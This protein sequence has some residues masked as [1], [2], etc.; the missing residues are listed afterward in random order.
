MPQRQRVQ[1]APGPAPPCPARAAASSQSR[2]APIASRIAGSRRP[3][4]EPAGL[5]VR[6]SRAAASPLA[7]PARKLAVSRV[8]ALARRPLA[9]S[10]RRTPRRAWRRPGPAPSGQSHVRRWPAA[11]CTRGSALLARTSSRAGRQR[12]RPQRQGVVVHGRAVLAATASASPRSSG[13][14]GGR[15]GRRSRCRRA[16]RG[17]RRRAGDCW[18]WR[19][20]RAPGRPGAACPRRESAPATGAAGPSPAGS[21]V[22]RRCGSGMRPAAWIADVPVDVGE[23]DA[24]RR[25][26]PGPHRLAELVGDR[27]GSCQQRR[28]PAAFV[29]PEPAQRH[30]AGLPRRRRQDLIDDGAVAREADRLPHRLAALARG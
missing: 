27:P 5:V 19:S 24:E 6:R 16:D 29:S 18:P 11:S 15:V 13:G 4:G 1:P 14:C 9:P 3:A 2:A 17:N 21:R 30:R 8:E 7:P 25:H 20:S 26:V 23:D 22:P 28:Q 12:T 10:A